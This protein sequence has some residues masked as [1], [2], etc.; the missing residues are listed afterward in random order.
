MLPVSAWPPGPPGA[1]LS[2]FGAPRTVTP[3]SCGCVLPK[4]A[5]VVDTG[6]NSVVMYRP[7]WRAAQYTQP[8]HQ[9]GTGNLPGKQQWQASW[10]TCP[11][12]TRP[13]HDQ[14]LECWRAWQRTTGNTDPPI[15]PLPGRVP[16]NFAGWSFVGAPS[17][18]LLQPG[19]SG[20]VLA[21]GQNVVIVGGGTST[22]TQAFSV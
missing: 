5:W 10:T 1:A 17:S 11:P 2:P 21:D 4:G 14:Y 13:T 20:T 7:D 15:R 22:I 6:T 12:T 16:P 19:Q 18:T 9:M 3:G 8:R